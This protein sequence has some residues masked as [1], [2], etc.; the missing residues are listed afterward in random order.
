VSAKSSSKS[1]SSKPKPSHHTIA[2]ETTFRAIVEEFASAANLIFLATGKAHERGYPLF[3]V[4]SNVDG[5]SGV[6]VYLE[7]D[8]V[9]LLDKGE[10][11]PVGL[12]QMVEKATLHK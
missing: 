2:A 7:N 4:S 5:K 10:W 6:T 9:F 1:S 11:R 3:R 8:V 12:E